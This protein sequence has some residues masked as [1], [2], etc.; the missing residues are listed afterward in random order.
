MHLR[1]V[2]GHRSSKTLR[3]TSSLCPFTDW[4]LCPFYSSLQGHK[5]FAHF[6]ASPSFIELWTLLA[7]F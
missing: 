7:D 1:L 4:T 6:T 5:T 2:L 3:I